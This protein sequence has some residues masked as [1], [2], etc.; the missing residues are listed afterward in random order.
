MC[1]CMWVGL[2]VSRCGRECGG[3][4]RLLEEDGQGVTMTE[5]TGGP[6]RDGDHY[7]LRRRARGGPV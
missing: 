3:V 2:H 6:W 5:G 1:V 7:G 4:R